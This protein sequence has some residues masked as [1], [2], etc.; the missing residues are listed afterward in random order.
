MTKKPLKT[1]IG[2]L[3]LAIILSIGSD[4]IADK[5]IPIRDDIGENTVEMVVPHAVRLVFSNFGAS[6]RHAF[7][8]NPQYRQKKRVPPTYKGVSA[9]KEK[10]E[11][12]PLDL[13]TTWDPEFYPYQLQLQ[14]GPTTEVKPV[15]TRHIQDKRLRKKL[16][17]DTITGD[18]IKVYSQDP[19]FTLLKKD[20]DSVTYIWPDPQRDKSELYLIKRFRRDGKFSLKMDVILL[21]T[22]KKRV[23]MRYAVLITGWQAPT[24]K[25]GGCG[26]SMFSPPP[27]LKEAMCYSDDSLESERFKGDKLIKAFDGNAS[28]A[29][30]STRYF[31][32][33]AAPEHGQKAQCSI[34]MYKFGVVESQLHE[35]DSL[36][37][38]SKDGACRP[39]LLG[40]VSDTMLCSKAANMLGVNPYVDAK[41]LSIAFKK[42]KSKVNEE[43]LDQYLK[44]YKA[45]A[46]RI[47]TRHSFLI[48]TG[49]K[50]ISELKAVDHDLRESVNF[51]VL[52]IPLGWLCIPMLWLMRLSYRVIPNW[53]VS[54]IFLTIV[55]KLL[56]LYW[57]QKSYEQMA[58]MQ[59]LKP[60]MD[61]IRKK[62]AKDR[63]ALNKAM[64]DLYKRHKVNPLGGCLPMLIQMPIWFALYRT[65]YSAVE[66][67]QA[68]LFLWIKDLSSYDP[69]FVLP[70]L[71]GIATFIQ[72]KLTP[73]TG[74]PGQ[75][76]MMMYVMPV[77]FTLF[78]LFLPSG[79]TFYILV[80]SILSIIHQWLIQKRG[81]LAA[82]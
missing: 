53:G 22:T 75:A 47:A 12:G 73:Q 25:H 20:K 54:I 44:A 80:N 66:L 30:V 29:A 37:A 18:F 41:G 28:F 5:P 27:D 49:P 63:D 57:T 72:Q 31:L 35:L 74:D 34:A 32:L 48:Y 40:P 79:L 2:L 52:G 81:L 45:L 19:L 61:R 3:S 17:K 55:V 15:V 78:M 77:M 70:I 7:M 59:A 6:I 36:I 56:T 21:S 46:S 58:K 67:Y 23:Q 8:L 11:E 69:Y 64:M 39:D 10:F 38:Y 50:D 16:K 33:A 9:P 76:K 68:P 4:S 1:F 14:W 43:Q 71:M 26:S 13:V 62:Y 51:R 24:E 42:K 82:R 60:E 65:I